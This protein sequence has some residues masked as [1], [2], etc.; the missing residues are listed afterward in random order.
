[1]FVWISLMTVIHGSC[2]STGDRISLMDLAG[3]LGIAVRLPFERGGIENR[4][5]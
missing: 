5:I 3:V 2:W 4:W 1:M